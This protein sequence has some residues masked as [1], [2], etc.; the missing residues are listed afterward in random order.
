MTA[1]QDAPETAGQST[2]PMSTDE[3]GW[4]RTGTEQQQEFFPCSHD[5]TPRKEANFKLNSADC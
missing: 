3:Y 4:I 5:A 2:V 1:A